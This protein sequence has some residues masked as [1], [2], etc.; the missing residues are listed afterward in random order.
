M[1]TSL[2]HSQLWDVQTTSASQQSGTSLSRLQLW[3]VRNHKCIQTI[4]DRQV[5]PADDTLMC[6]CYDFKRKRLL[7]GAPAPVLRAWQT[8]GCWGQSPSG[9]LRHARKGKGFIAVPAHEGSSA[10]A[11]GILRHARKGK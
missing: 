4:S 11:D 5:Y 7:T 3:D 6:M 2:S 9:I 10:G 1:G 8:D